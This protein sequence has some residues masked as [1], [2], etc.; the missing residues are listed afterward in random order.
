MC[1]GKLR[2]AIKTK[3][4]DRMIQNKYNNMIQ[5]ALFLVATS[6]VLT[7]VEDPARIPI[8]KQGNLEF[9]T[10][11]NI[12]RRRNL[13]FDPGVSAVLNLFWRVGD[14]HKTSMDKITEEEYKAFM[15]R[16]YKVV[17][18][19]FTPT[20]ASEAI[21]ID[22][23]KDSKGLGYMTEKMLR[24]GLFELADTWCLDIDGREYEEFLF[25]I[26]KNVTFGSPPMFRPIEDIKFDGSVLDGSKGHH[27]YVDEEEEKRKK[28]EMEEEKERKER[29]KK[30]SIPVAVHKK[31]IEKKEDSDGN[32]I[33]KV[34]IPKMRKSTVK[35][36]KKNVEDENKN[37]IKDNIIEEN[38]IK[39]DKSEE[40]DK[41]DIN[42]NNNEIKTMFVPLKLA[43]PK[44]DQS[45]KKFKNVKIGNIVNNNESNNNNNTDNN[46][47]NNNNDSPTNTGLNS[48]LNNGSLLSNSN[49]NGINGSGNGNGNEGANGEGNKNGKGKDG[50]G[51]DGK[52]EEEGKEREGGEG[53]ENGENG[54]GGVDGNNNNANG[55]NNDSKTGG[56]A[57][58]G[59][60]K[61]G[62]GRG[63]SKSGKSANRTSSPNGKRKSSSNRKSSP[64]NGRKSS[65]NNGRKK[66]IKPG[67]SGGNRLNGIGENSEGGNGE[68]G[69]GDGSGNGL[70]DSSG[71]I[72]SSSSGGYNNGG[73]GSGNSGNRKS[74]S[75]GKKGSGSSGKKK[76][77][78]K[79]K[80][81]NLSSTTGSSNL[82]SDPN[83]LSSSPAV[84]YNDK[85]YND[86]WKP[87]GVYDKHHD[88]YDTEHLHPNALNNN[89]TPIDGEAWKSVSSTLGD[90]NIEYIPPENG[91]ATGDNKDGIGRMNTSLDGS[92]TQFQPSIT[93]GNEKRKSKRV[94]KRIS[95]SVNRLTQLNKDKNPST[96]YN[97]G[98]YDDNNSTEAWLPSGIIRKHND[99]YI[100]D[101]TKVD[102]T[103]GDNYSGI[104]E[105]NGNWRPGGTSEE[106]LQ[107]DIYITNEP[108]IDQNGVF[109]DPSGSRRT[110][111]WIP[112]GLI[113]Q[114]YIPNST[115]GEKYVN[116][117]DNSFK[118]ESKC[119][120]VT[121]KYAD[122]STGY[123]PSGL[124]TAPYADV[125]IFLFLFL[126]AKR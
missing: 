33:K 97:S 89:N 5:E 74:K 117:T 17:L 101:P 15:M 20:Q 24:D 95:N 44:L 119:D 104:K 96:D 23:I 54:E 6:Q 88:K 71:G 22:W 112:A 19:D 59:G 8:W 73:S 80:D 67:S 50:E 12:R 64:N 102:Q 39:D 36:E 87:S 53:K 72:G 30:M 107:Q 123:E 116:P 18:L 124:N 120:I 81:R 83:N 48:G 29:E 42:E 9:Y 32:A 77:N 106:A 27:E 100:T 66:S 40:N 126:I 16:V 92:N 114:R 57:A 38:E 90:R 31:S 51:K 76:G 49:N 108:F 63:K 68:N 52:G 47:S 7:E 2:A 113:E 45:T 118:R 13:Q 35:N 46:N 121:T 98:Y 10:P 58:A 79:Y 105:Y 93:G 60:G 69:S 26:Y 110:S 70:G 34:K 56:G 103:L 3:S 62:G 28:K 111:M 91:N 43:A 84:N 125:Y 78:D 109:H 94:S 85:E 115:N 4:I 37:D 11:E 86:D 61:D 122:Y 21:D 65:P 14:F 75:G 41:V 25:K 55:N 82:N 99:I 1:W